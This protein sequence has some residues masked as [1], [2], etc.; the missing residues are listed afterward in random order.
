MGPKYPFNVC[1][2]QTKLLWQTYCS[3][4]IYENGITY[5]YNMSLNENKQGTQNNTNFLDFW[6]KISNMAIQNLSNE[7]SSLPVILPYLFS[8][9]AKLTNL[10][11]NIL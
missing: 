10:G 11:Y 9:I 2:R 5:P 8:L 4:L 1:G 3:E 6:K 7:N